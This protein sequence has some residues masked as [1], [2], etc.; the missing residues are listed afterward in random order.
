M[1][2]ALATLL[3]LMMLLSLTPAQAAEKKLSIVCTTFPTYDWVREILGERVQD[4]DL[5][6][7]QDN[8][9]DLHNFQPTAADFVKVSS[10]DLFAY[11]GGPSDEWVEDAVK[12]AKNKNL[13]A[14]NLIE[15][16]GDMVKEEVS[17]EGMQEGKHMHDH[18]E[19]DHD[20]DHEHSHGKEV[21]TFEDN[22]V[23]DRS[24]NDW[25][26]K[27]QSAYPLVLDG[28][29]DKVFEEKAESGKMTAEEYKKYYEEGYKTDY[30][31]ISIDG[32]TISFTDSKGNTAASDY[33]YVGYVLQD[34]S[35]G[36]RAALYRFEARDKQA[37]TPA[38]IEFNDHMIEP[39]DAEH[40]HI[41]MSSESFDAITDL[42]T[43]WPTFYPADLTGEQICEEIIAHG[44]HKE[45]KDDHDEKAAE[46]HDHDHDEHD[47]EGHAHHHEDE[48][49]WLS[50]RNAEKLVKVLAEKLS[51][52]D[53]DHAALYAANT[54]A[55]L[56]KLKAL[57]TEYRSVVHSAKGKTVLFADRFPFLY[58]TEDYGLTP[59]AAFSGCS[60]ETE[61]S[62][63]TIA[64]LANKMD[65]LSLPVVMTIEGSDQRIAKAVL[66]ASKDAG[67]PIV[68]MDSIQAVNRDDMKTKTYLSIMQSNLETLKQALQ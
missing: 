21:S 10:A 68:T 42:E 37:G 57:D 67:R 27:W 17:L 29:L 43:S 38:Y 12:E 28:K 33:D 39:A 50:L 8:G 55:Y 15:E 45:D 53:A 34:W 58:L 4:V 11:V 44:Q 41:R 5:S 54:A 63:E 46:D 66:S 20:H 59:F 7:L 30:T 25:A 26:G 22:E 36:T 65:E 32:Q 60:A 64:F 3:T 48:H 6:L 31:H 24:L 9:V 52:I 49:V 14:V 1:K 19:E 13:V 47:H 18:E 62:F 61:A 51:A 40:F 35:S 16:L 2:K 56:E 23:K